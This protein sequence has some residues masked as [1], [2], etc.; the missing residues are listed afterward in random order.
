MI[1]GLARTSYTVHRT[2]KQSVRFLNSESG[3]NSTELSVARSKFD[4]GNLFTAPAVLH[5]KANEIISH[6]QKVYAEESHESLLHAFYRWCDIFGLFSRWNNR[7]Y[8]GLTSPPLARMNAIMMTEYE[9]KLQIFREFNIQVFLC[10]VASF[11]FLAYYYRSSRQPL[12]QIVGLEAPFR[13]TMG[14]WSNFPLQYPKRR[15]P[16]CRP[17]DPECK[18]IRKR[19][20]FLLHYIIASPLQ[21]I[22]FEKLRAAG[23]KLFLDDTKLRAWSTPRIDL[24]PSPYTNP[25]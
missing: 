24:K 1:V 21:K 17:Y 15:C 10:L 18:V 7:K 22:C 20:L 11:G 25:K 16:H 4:A 12:P 3:G 5:E 6:R 2:A 13:A 23:Y 19:I 14:A 8:W 9:R